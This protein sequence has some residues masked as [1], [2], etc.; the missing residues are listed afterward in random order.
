MTTKQIDERIS[1]ADQSIGHLA[2]MGALSAVIVDWQKNNPEKNPL[3]YSGE[4]Y[5]QVEKKY[6]QLKNE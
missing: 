4:F 2:T 6:Q 3:L 1:A 5:D